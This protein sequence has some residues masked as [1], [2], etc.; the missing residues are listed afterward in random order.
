MRRKRRTSRRPTYAECFWGGLCLVLA[1]GMWVGAVYGLS[2]LVENFWFGL[3]WELGLLIL[4]LLVVG[5]I[6]AM[7]GYYAL[8]IHP[9]SR[10]LRA[11]TDCHHQAWLDGTSNDN[12]KS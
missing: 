1:V 6:L 10:V 4:G 8:L 5:A 12:C 3:T 7:L 9:N 11:I 2:F